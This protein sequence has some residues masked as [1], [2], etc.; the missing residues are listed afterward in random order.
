MKPRNYSTCIAKQK[1]KK[2]EATQPA[3]LVL[4][5]LYLQFHLRNIITEKDLRSA[6]VHYRALE[7]E[8]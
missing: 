4:I 1:E 6:V 8:N 3:L 2:K 7:F 5:I